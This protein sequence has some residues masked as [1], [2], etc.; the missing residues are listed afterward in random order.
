MTGRSTKDGAE[1]VLTNH[2]V[3][4]NGS[5]WQ[6]RYC[7]RQWPFP[8]PLPAGSGPCV[9][10]RWG[11]TEPVVTAG[12][13]FPDPTPDPPKLMPPEYVKSGPSALDNPCPKCHVRPGERCVDLHRVNGLTDR[14]HTERR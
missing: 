12:H 4:R 10:R 5:F 11:D 7:L 3:F 9:P 8:S 1:T 2:S 6:C 13:A 14:P